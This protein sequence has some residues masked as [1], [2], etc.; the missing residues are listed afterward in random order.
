VS[1]EVL[2]GMPPLLGSSEVVNFGARYLDF[3]AASPSKPFQVVLD[4]EDR[5]PLEAALI[6]WDSTGAR[7]PSIA[8]FDLDNQAAGGTVTGPLGYDRH[9]LVV[10]ARDG[11]GAPNSYAFAYSGTTDPPAGIQFLDMGGDDPFYN[12]VGVLLDRSVVSG[13][14]VPPDSGLWFFNG[15]N[16]VTRQQFAKMIMEAIE[17]HTDGVDNPGHPTFR[18]VPL[19]WDTNGYPYDYI[20]EAAELHIVTGNG[21]G[22]FRPTAY[23]TRV[24]LVLMI[25]RGARAAGKTLPEY[26]GNERHF[27]DVPVTHPYYREIMAAWKA[28]IMD[29]SQAADG[30]VY[31]HPYSTASR[32]HVAKMTAQLL[33]FLA[34]P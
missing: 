15:K 26:D 12:Y 7:A 32:D 14:Q 9:T 5:A 33:A 21:A 19:V 17:M 22:L 2:A 1:T 34:V 13:S 8:R 28:G 30:K 18:D 24:Q 31:F 16:N 23:I 4:G 11:V 27:A 10:W 6:S 3:P 29:G 25:G 20:E